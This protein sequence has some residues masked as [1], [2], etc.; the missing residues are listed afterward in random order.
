MRSSARQVIDLTRHS[1]AYT[2]RNAAILELA[3]LPMRS[4]P[5]IASR[6][7]IAKTRKW[8]PLEKLWVAGRGCERVG[9]GERVGRTA[10]RGLEGR[11]QRPGAS[12][13]P[14]R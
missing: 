2:G 11:G 12:P 14:I 5:V 1:A 13:S 9:A 4:Y 8:A 10:R 7:D 3:W 6:P